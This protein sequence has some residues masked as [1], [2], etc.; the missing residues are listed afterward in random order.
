MK[1]DRF[2]DELRRVILRGV[3][4]SAPPSLRSRVASIST[5]A[6]SHHGP[7]RLWTKPQLSEAFAAVVAVV[8]VVIVASAVLITRVPAAAPM[9]STTATP[10]PLASATPAGPVVTGLLVGS[11]SATPSIQTGYVDAIAFSD[12]L[13]GLM[14]G[15]S[16]VSILT[17]VTGGPDIVGPSGTAVVWRTDD[18]GRTWARYAVEA[19]P[20][21][22][23]SAISSS[24]A[25]A[26]AI[27]SQPRSPNCYDGVYA[28]SN[29]GLA[30]S[31]IADASI[32]SLSLIDATN[33]WGID[34]T[35]LQGG[36]GRVLR[37]TSDGGRTWSDAPAN[38]CPAY[39]SPITVSFANAKLGWLGCAGPSSA[40]AG[41]KAVLMTSDGGRTW[42]LQA[43]VDPSG[44]TGVAVVG[45]IPGDGYLSG[46]SMTTDGIG[47]IWG[48]LGSILWTDDGGRVWRNVVPSGP[49]WASAMA[50]YVSATGEATVAL[51]DETARRQVLEQTSDAGRTWHELAELPFP[52]PSPL[53]S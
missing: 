45:S 3:P 30:W 19:P 23:I 51:L 49:K 38:P 14:V 16:S 40:G 41:A 10:T 36:P 4:R 11:A 21:V 18:G 6:D 46:L 47:V 25:L 15:G 20:F 29:G 2:D 50:G 7:R 22:S 53:G 42:R 28:T 26:G 27:C 39:L 52:A 48:A 12:N 35:L 1:D 24:V 9:A 37:S 8:A 32:V 33:G 44:G 43:A 31:R 17:A 5:G 13:H 34:W